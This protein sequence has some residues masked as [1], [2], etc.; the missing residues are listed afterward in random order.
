MRKIFV[1]LFVI[2]S[3]ACAAQA[4]FELG[5]IKIDSVYFKG[6]SKWVDSLVVNAKLPS[7]SDQQIPSAKAVKE[8]VVDTVSNM[9]HDSIVTMTASIASLSDSVYKH[10]DTLQLHDNRLKAMELIDHTHSNKAILDATTASFTTTLSTAISTAT[11]VNSSQTTSIG[12]LNDSLHWHDNKEVLDSITSPFTDEKDTRLMGVNDTILIMLR[13][14][15]DTLTSSEVK[16]GY[17]LPINRTL[18]GCNLI[19]VEAFSPHVGD[20]T[21]SVNVYR[22]RS[23]SL[24]L[25]TSTGASINGTA[26]INTLFDDVTTGDYYDFGYSESGATTYTVS[27]DVYLKFLRP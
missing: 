8:F 21:A 7:A 22:Y 19:S 1:F 3:A 25:V 15:D 24:E 27:V 23:G 18:N 4:P 9:I 14:T 26:T 12:I 2:M 6:T 16:V 5:A 17:I 20:G 10:T 13:V 11:S